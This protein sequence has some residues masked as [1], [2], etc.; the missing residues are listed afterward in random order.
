MRYS[1]DHP[2]PATL[3]WK[4]VAYALAKG[5]TMQTARAYATLAW[6]GEHYGIRSP[7]ITSGRRSAEYQAELR[8]RWDAGDRRGLVTRPALTSKHTEGRAFDLAGDA[9]TLQFLG[10]LAP[11]AGLRWGGTFGDSDPVHF[12]L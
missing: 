2:P 1:T 12:D 8:R 7:S 4:N 3:W 6:W 10:R 5:L 11:H 9:A